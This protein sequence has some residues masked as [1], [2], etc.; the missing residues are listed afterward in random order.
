MIHSAHYI[1][2]VELVAK[3]EGGWA[4]DPRDPGGATMKGIIQRN[5]DAYRDARKLPR[6]S[7]R[8]IEDDEVATIYHGFWRSSGADKVEEAGKPHLAAVTF[9]WG[10]NAG[11]ERG[12]R[13]LQA[14]VGIAPAQVDGILGPKSIA[15][16]AQCD[17]HA[18]VARYLE[19]RALHYRIRS[20]E[21]RPPDGNECLARLTAAGLGSIAPDPHPPSAAFRNAWYARLRSCARF[22]GVPIP[23][24]YERPVQATA[25][26][27][28]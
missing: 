1:A 9:D 15:A 27:R 28:A 3:H 20:C 14:A 16:I 24:L 8:L 25:G 10:F 5:Y 18:A 17:E 23:P 21:T 19:L 13:Y 12:R 11:P 7:V 22:C 2:A 26:R 6:R 4:N